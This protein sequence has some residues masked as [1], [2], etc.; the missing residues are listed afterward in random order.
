LQQV[1]EHNV[2]PR[3]THTRQ[4]FPHGRVERMADTFSLPG[5]PSH[6]FRP[7]VPPQKPA[8]KEDEKFLQYCKICEGFKPPRSHHCQSC[9][10]CVAK[11]DH[12]CPWI[13]SCVGNKNHAAF[14]GFVCSVPV[15]CTYAMVIIVF[16]LMEYCPS[17][18]AAIWISRYQP[19]FFDEIV[20]PGNGM[21]G[22][23]CDRSN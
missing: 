5:H 6:Q 22:K 4:L 17:I 23:R 15:G 16:Y 2:P 11:M 18:R 13:N 9:G 3:H 19:Q 14:L 12:H 8:K 1:D 7:T 10:H 20:S 21:R